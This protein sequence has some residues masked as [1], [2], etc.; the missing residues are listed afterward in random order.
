[1]KRFF[2]IYLLFSFI[3]WHSTRNKIEHRFV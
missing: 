1:M 2:W 3:S